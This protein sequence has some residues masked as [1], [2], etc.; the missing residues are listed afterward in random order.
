MQSAG[1]DDSFW[2]EEVSFPPLL[3]Y[4]SRA[5]LHPV[6][7]PNTTAFSPSL[8]LSV[9]AVCVLYRAENVEN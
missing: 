4:F 6:L 2:K 5:H 8:S 3:F 1:R 9:C 7:I